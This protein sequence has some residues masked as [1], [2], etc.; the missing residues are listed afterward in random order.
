MVPAEQRAEFA[1]DLHDFG[2][3]SWDPTGGGLPAD[4]CEAVCRTVP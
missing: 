3:C 2:L 1:R 4:L